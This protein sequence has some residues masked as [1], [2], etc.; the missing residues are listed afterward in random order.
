MKSPGIEVKPIK[1]LTGGSSF[2]EVYFNDVVIPDSQRLGEIGDGWKVAITT[3][4]NERLAV[5]DADGV[6]ANEAFEL[7]KKRK[8]GE[9]LIDNNAVRES[10]ALIGIVRH[11]GLKIQNSGLCQHFLEEI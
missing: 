2:N 1:Q 8:D 4:M 7:A 5:G 10:I 11:Q 9:Q 6:D 3:L